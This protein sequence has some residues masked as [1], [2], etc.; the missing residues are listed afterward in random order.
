MHTLSPFLV[1]CPIRWVVGVE[2]LPAGILQEPKAT[3]ILFFSSSFL[4]AVS[5]DI[6]LIL[7]YSTHLPRLFMGTVKSEAMCPLN[8]ISFIPTGS[9]TEWNIIS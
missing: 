5:L 6:R 1:A 9:K 8:P 2:V 7:P 3:N 4:P